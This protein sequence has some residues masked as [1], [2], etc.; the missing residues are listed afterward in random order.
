MTRKQKFELPTIEPKQFSNLVEIE[1]GIQKLKSR[2]VDLNK[3]QFKAGALDQGNWTQEHMHH[4][5]PQ[6]GV[7]TRA[8]RN[9]ILEVFGNT[10]PQWDYFQHFRIWHGG[11]FT[12][13]TDSYMQQCFEKGIV[14]AIEQL[15]GE[16]SALEEKKADFELD[17][18]SSTAL[19]SA[20]T[21]M[22]EG[23]QTLKSSGGT[24]FV[25][26]PIGKEGSEERRRSDDLLE[27]IISP[28]MDVFGFKV[29]R[30]DRLHD[31]GKITE[32]IIEQ[33]HT[34]DLVIADLTA[35]N[36]NVFYELGVR[37]TVGKPTVQLIQKGGIVPFDVKVI[38]TLEYDLQVREAKQASENLRKTVIWLMENPSKPLIT[39][40]IPV[41]QVHK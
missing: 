32:Q 2:I 33:L 31:P 15:Q 23:T 22:P 5:N 6:V 10:S 21:I 26:C 17:A 14:H 1:R 36:A 37:H 4:D 18:N 16:V 11:L 8:I 24:C 29:I 7:V 25:I 9:T 39:Q 19:P 30:A 35:N 28:V 34:A 27:H 20:I 13:M 3:L 38:R 12:N 40:P 41:N